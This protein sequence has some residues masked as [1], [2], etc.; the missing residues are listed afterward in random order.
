[1]KSCI[2]HLLALYSVTLLVGCAGVKHALQLPSDARDLVGSERVAALEGLA[3]LRGTPPDFR[4]LFRVSIARGNERQ[5][6]R[7]AIVFGN[8]DNLRF[9]TLPVGSAYTLATLVVGEKGYRFL[10]F[11]AHEVREGSSGSAALEEFLALPFSS[12]EVATLLAGRVPQKWLLSKDRLVVSARTLS[13]SSDL[14]VAGATEESEVLLEFT[15][16]GEHRLLSAAKFVGVGRHNRL[17]DISW[18]YGL[19]D[20]FPQGF[21][22]KIPQYDFEVTAER[23]SLKRGVTPVELFQVEAPANFSREGAG[24]EVAW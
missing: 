16:Q 10:D 4:G 2:S 21:T 8:P 13:A 9:D 22:L 23:L 14:L 15:L 7:Y 12:T 18:I 5:A 1:M 24:P 17:I 11:V 19:D 3:S 20:P 6:V